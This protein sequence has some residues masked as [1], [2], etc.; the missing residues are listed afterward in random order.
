MTDL[1]NCISVTYLKR[2]QV[3]D[4]AAANGICVEIWGVNLATAEDIWHI[5][6]EQARAW[7]A[8][9]WS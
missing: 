7:A 8:I 1:D 2:Q 5:G 3:W 4:W 9:K 6:N